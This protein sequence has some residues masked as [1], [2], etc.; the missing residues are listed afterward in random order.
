MSEVPRRETV[1]WAVLVD[2]NAFEDRGQR[3]H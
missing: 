3:T 1:F 2:D